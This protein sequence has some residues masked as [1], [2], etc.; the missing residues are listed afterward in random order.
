M[1]L[2]TWLKFR[3]RHAHVRIPAGVMD[4]ASVAEAKSLKMIRGHVEKKSKPRLETWTMP[5]V[6]GHEKESEKACVGVVW[7]AGMSCGL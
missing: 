1:K 7:K 6:K 2:W 3:E 5:K 4:I